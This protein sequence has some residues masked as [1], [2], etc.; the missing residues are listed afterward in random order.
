MAR[1]FSEITQANKRSFL[2]RYAETGRLD[3]AADLASCS[4]YSHYHW[5]KDDPEYAAAFAEARAMVAD[6]LEDEA[7]RR[8]RDGIDKPIYYKGLRVDTIRDYS[9]SLLMFLLK[10]R[11]PEVYRDNVDITSGGQVL[12]I[13]I[14]GGCNV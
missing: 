9:D 6:R 5:I 10:G 3:R 14:D 8:A 4:V 1:N 2:N 11:R 7:V 12:R 13:V